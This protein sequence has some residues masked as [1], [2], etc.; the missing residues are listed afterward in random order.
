MS[1]PFS[2]DALRAAVGKHLADNGQ[3]AFPRI[4]TGKFNTSYYVSTRAGEYVLRI[5]PPPETPCLFYERDMMKQEPGIHALLLAKTDVPVARIIAF[6][7]SHETLPSDFLLMERLPGRAASESTLSPSAVDRLFEHTGKALR[8]I[9][10]Q[11]ADR[12]GYLG[13][14]HC[15][16]PQHTWKSAFLVMWNKLLDDIE[17]TSVYAPEEVDRMRGLL[18]NHFS[19][20]DHEVRPQLLHMDIW[21]QNLLC[22]A[23]GNLTGLVDFDRALWGDPE[24]EFA[25]LD[26]C[27]VSTGAFWKG[28]GAE[29]PSGRDAGIRLRFY[30]LYELQKYVVI[31]ALRRSDHRTADA[32][33]AHALSLAGEL[34]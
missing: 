5:A 2:E 11:E 21:A 4:A 34:G 8:A 12:Y 9:H 24:I 6:D 25:V 20:F 28:Y 30:F 31:E 27:G 10:A 19:S 23:S 29:R 14:H 22:D 26:Y 15:M 13:E 32:Y 16:E 3:M 18:A 1:Q 17:T 7:E 33:R